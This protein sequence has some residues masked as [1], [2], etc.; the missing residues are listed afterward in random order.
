MNLER[1]LTHYVPVTAKPNKPPER[2]PIND[3]GEIGMVWGK[4]S[5]FDF[6]HGTIR[7]GGDTGWFIKLK[8]SNQVEQRTEIIDVEVEVDR[9][10]REW[11][12]DQRIPGHLPGEQ[13]KITIRALVP[14]SITWTTKITVPRTY[15]GQAKEPERTYDYFLDKASKAVQ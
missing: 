9:D 14:K 12:D 7:E 1:V 8:D 15:L 11:V 6:S 5:S 13:A 3:P 10:E 4:G 2:Q